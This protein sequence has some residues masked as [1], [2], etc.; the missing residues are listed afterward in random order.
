MLE[1]NT[2]SETERCLIPKRGEYNFKNVPLDD[3]RVWSLYCRGDCKGIFQVESALSTVYS[4]RMKPRSIEELSI[5]I[6][7]IRPGVLE[8]GQADVL[9]KRK[10]GDEEIS[11]FHPFL[12]PILKDTFGCLVFQEQSIR[13]AVE[14]AGMSESDAD[15][16][17]RKT[18]AKKLPEKI[19]KAKELFLA[20]CKEK[21]IINEKEAEE[22]FSWI[23]KGQRYLFNASHS[24]SYSLISYLG[25]YQKCHFYTEWLCS[26]LTL[27]SDKPDPKEE[28]YELVQDA[29]LHDTLI[30][31]PI[32]SRKNKDFQIIKDKEIAFG[33]SHIRG[34]GGSATESILPAKLDSFTD[35][36]KASKKIKRSV[37]ESLIKSGAC[38]CYGISRSYMLKVLA[39]VYGKKID[40]HL[41]GDLPSQYKPLTGKELPVF[42]ANLDKSPINAMKEVIHQKGCMDKR[43]PVIE[44]K[45]NWLSIGAEDTNTQRALWESLFLGLPLSCSAIND[46][47][48]EER[49]LKT[50]RQIYSLP[51]K[52]NF[53]TFVVI[54]EIIYKTTGPKSKNPGSPYVYLKCSDNTIGLQFILWPDNYLKY[55]DQ[56]TDNSVIVIKGRKDNWNGRENYIINDIRVIG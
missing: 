1:N 19:A 52:E 15:I 44:S 54:D 13:I 34:I 39:A 2:L 21:G 28:L 47:S 51:N 27:S 31:P 11:Y 35:L 24:C 12:E 16:H 48:I 10:N 4:K 55:K 20:G 56:I 6:S 29:R 43:I 17:I 33:L 3:Q 25:A 26:A 32:I 46:Y 37:C 41:E 30:L 38:D 50:C 18:L 14:L 45:I 40:K 5:L 8:T 42:L 49:N 36:L 22:I 9:I 7:I 23:E 53:T